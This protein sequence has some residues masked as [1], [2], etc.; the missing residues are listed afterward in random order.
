MFTH[1]H[2]LEFLVAERRSRLL[3]DSSRIGL[4]RL[5]RRRRRN[6]EATSEH[7]APVLLFPGAEHPP[8]SRG[9]RDAAA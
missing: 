4:A 1:P 8:R 3:A 2:T 6:A 9:D 7:T 5:A